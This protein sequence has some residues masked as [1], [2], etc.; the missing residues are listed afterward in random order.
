M[1]FKNK[2]I[3][4]KTPPPVNHTGDNSSGIKSKFLNTFLRIRYYSP[5]CL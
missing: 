4:T 2:H 3:L 1:C 5:F